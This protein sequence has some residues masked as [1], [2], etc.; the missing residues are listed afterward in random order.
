VHAVEA[1]VALAA[2]HLADH[3]DRLGE[4]R[5]RLGG[6]AAWATV[7]RGRVREAAGAQP[8]LHPTAAEHVQARGG[9]GQHRR[10]AQRQVGDVGKDADP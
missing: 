8:Q 6:A 2:P 7:R 4:R 10:R 1:E 3:L 5:E 9:L